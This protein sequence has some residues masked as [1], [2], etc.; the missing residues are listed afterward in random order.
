MPGPVTLLRRIPTIPLLLAFLLPAL[1]GSASAQLRYGPAAA[2]GEG[3]ARAYVSL[4]EDGSPLELGIAIDEAAMNTLPELPGVP[5]E[6]AFVV[7]NLVLPDG[8][9]TPFRTAMLDWNPRGH[10]P[11]EIYGLPHFDFH[12][13]LI[14]DVEREAIDPSDPEWAAKAVRAPAPEFLPAGYVLPENALETVVVP[15]MGTHWIDPASGEFQGEEFDRTFIYGTW[16]GRVVFLEPMITKAYLVSGAGG[17]RPI[18]A[19]ERRSPAGL[20][21]T[22]YDVAFDEEAGEYRVSLVDFVAGQ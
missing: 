17:E 1:P 13:Y 14:D 15:A 4:A 21:P 7:V 11:A 16:N 18:A 2:L 9:G 5:P 20:Y 6:Q 10:V 22:A 19:P 12:F 3:T 8:H